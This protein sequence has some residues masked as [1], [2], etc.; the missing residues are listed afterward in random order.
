MALGEAE[1][2]PGELQPAGSILL[3]GQRNAGEKALITATEL[4]DAGLVTHFDLPDHEQTT[5]L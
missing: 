1:E 4:V 5:L 2:L 3:S